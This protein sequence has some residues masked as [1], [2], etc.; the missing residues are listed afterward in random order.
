MLYVYGAALTVMALAFLAMSINQLGRHK[1][2]SIAYGLFASAMFAVLLV[3]GLK[4][5]VVN[6]GTV[7]EFKSLP[8]FVFYGLMFGSSLAVAGLNYFY[9]FRE[10]E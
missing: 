5:E 6:N 1:T 10:V 9:T 8:L 3:A 4:T 2:A 7:F